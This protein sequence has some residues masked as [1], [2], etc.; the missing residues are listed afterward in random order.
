V[1]II[2]TEISLWKQKYRDIE[3]EKQ[4]LLQERLQEKELFNTC[5]QENEDMKK[6]I[7]QLE[8]DQFSKVRGT[9]I[10]N[11][12]TAQAKNKKLKELKTGA[13]KALYFSELFGLQLACLRLKEPDTSKTYTVEVNTTKKGSFDLTRWQPT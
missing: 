9:A 11:L 3:K 7:R 4:D 10:P 12:Q 8:K 5:N 2:E 6:Y 1:N 13:Q